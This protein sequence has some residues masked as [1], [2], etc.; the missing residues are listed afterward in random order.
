[1]SVPLK[2]HTITDPATGEI[3]ETRVLDAVVLK[4]T[5][6]GVVADCL[7]ATPQDAAKA[8]QIS[9]GMPVQIR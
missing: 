8:K 3:L 7:P 2:T 4:V 1:M 9:V 5:R 6:C